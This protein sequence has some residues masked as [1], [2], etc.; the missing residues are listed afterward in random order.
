[1]LHQRR[2]GTESPEMDWDY[3]GVHDQSERQSQQ[4]R[5]VHNLGRTSGKEKELPK[6]A[7][8]M[9]LEGEPYSQSYGTFGLSVVR[10]RYS[11]EN[12]QR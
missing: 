7:A 5:E 1:M 12:C 2:G 6:R 3:Y 10:K 11:C 8:S 9:P 4:V